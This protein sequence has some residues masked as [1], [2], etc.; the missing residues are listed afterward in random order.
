MTD[1]Y[2]DA[3]I[4]FDEQVRELFLGLGERD[5]LGNTLVVICTD[6]GMGF[7]VNERLPLI[8]VFPGGANAGRIAA[9]VQNLDIAPTVLDFLG[10]ERPEWME[11]FSLIAGEMPRDRTIFTIDR[12]YGVEVGD[13][14]RLRLDRRSIGP[15]FYSLGSIGAVLC[16]RLYN[17]RLDEMVL[18]VSRVEGHTA[19]CGDEEMPHAQYI[20]RLILDRLMADGY[21]VSSIKEPLPIRA[22]E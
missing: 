6:H 5:L 1:F 12:V 9:N 21:D 22:V 3:I 15:P 13:L 11:G 17:L 16:D 14:A 8:F 19:P 20:V 7:T 10:I 18:E 4:G 2:D